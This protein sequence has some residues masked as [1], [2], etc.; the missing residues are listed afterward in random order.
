MWNRIFFILR[1]FNTTLSLIYECTLSEKVTEKSLSHQHSHQS[2][3]RPPRSRYHM[4]VPKQIL[5]DGILSLQF[6]KIW[7]C[8][9]FRQTFCLLPK[10]F[11]IHQCLSCISQLSLGTYYLTKNMTIYVIFLLRPLCDNSRYKM[12]CLQLT[13]YVIIT[14]RRYM[15]TF[16]I[17]RH[18]MWDLQLSSIFT[19][20]PYILWLLYSDLPRMEKLVDRRIREQ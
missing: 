4:E 12:C 17:L 16:L 7:D 20:W 1:I 11:N 14:L 6:I 18:C 19:P 15:C 2:S 10:S 5:P 9:R 13:A 3:S 8:V